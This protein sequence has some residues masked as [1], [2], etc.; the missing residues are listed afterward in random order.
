M[1]EHRPIHF[2]NGREL[3]DVLIRAGLIA[4]LVMFCFDIFKPFLSLMLWAVILAITLYPVNQRLGGWLGGRNGLA[5][6][7]LVIVGLACLIGPLSLLGTSIAQSVHAG[8]QGFED[9]VIEIPPPP[10]NVRDWPLIGAPLYGI[11]EH[12]SSDLSWALSQ[13]APHL[14]GVSKTLLT[15]L[16]GI[17]SG[18]LVFVLALIIAGIIMAKGETGHRTGVAI[19]TRI[20]GP[21]R[22][23]QLAELCTSTIRAVAQG[24][25]GIAFIQ[26]ILVGI[27]LVIMGVP[28]AGVLA[29]L[30]LLLGITQLP[31]L[32]ITLPIVVY[33][34]AH[35]GVGA[36]TVIFAIWTILAGL[37]DN[38]LKP[39]LLGRGVAVPMPVVLI[40]AL[41]GMLT[42]GIIGL[43][44]GPVL[45]AV[46]YE[47]FMS[48]VAQPLAVDK[49]EPSPLQDELAPRQSL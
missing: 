46:G 29:L 13:V 20:S 18:I 43:F 21:E 19:A 30:V 11:W 48:W 34:F 28:A 7:L 39:L 38:V 4:V 10:A 17:G 2:G 36:S 33:V 23:P 45:L 26:M 44:I 1:A 49:P 32:L 15:Q 16:A 22:G 40:G 47:L 37:S 27:G 25:V 31:V 14:K 6:V 42:N 5:A 41:G 9:Q 24:V 3:L 8:I 35:D 12:A